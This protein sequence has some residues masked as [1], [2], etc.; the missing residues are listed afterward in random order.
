MGV[1]M[2]YLININ[3]LIL[4]LFLSTPINACTVLYYSD[5]NIILVGNNE[6]WPEPF[7]KIWYIPGEESKYGVVYFGWD[8]QPQGGMNAQGLFYDFTATPFLK[9]TTSEGKASFKTIGK[10]R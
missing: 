2:K 6:D 4:L 8:G 7:T 10:T 1:I 3:F 9:V 5:G